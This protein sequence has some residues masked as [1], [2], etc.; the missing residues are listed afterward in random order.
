MLNVIKSFA[1]KSNNQRVQSV[2][3]SLEKIVNQEKSLVDRLIQPVFGVIELRFASL[4]CSL[5]DLVEQVGKLAKRLDALMPMVSQ[6]RPGCKPLVIF[7]DR[8]IHET[9]YCNYERT[10]AIDTT[11][12]ILNSNVLD[13]GCG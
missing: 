12:Y 8:G 9:D 13:I 7:E 1:L 3:K 5:A 4:E 11:V 2:V 6:P 10:Y